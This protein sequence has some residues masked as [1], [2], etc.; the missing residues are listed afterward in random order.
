MTKL[1]DII[2]KKIPW[3]FA[4]SL[5]TECTYSTRKIV[6]SCFPAKQISA[7]KFIEIIPT[8]LLKQRIENVEQSILT[9]GTECQFYK[10][11]NANILA[12]LYRALENV[13]SRC[14]ICLQTGNQQ[15]RQTFATFPQDTRFVCN[16]RSVTRTV[17]RTK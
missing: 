8:P 9:G 10:T 3:Q 14:S 11:K 17:L 1:T 13:F 5:R 6:G 15:R 2:I 7:I 12:Q 4:S 16:K